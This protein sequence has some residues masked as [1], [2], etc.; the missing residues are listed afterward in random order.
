[1]RNYFHSEFKFSLF[2]HALRRG[3]KRDEAIVNGTERSR[4][5]FYWRGM[6]MRGFV[7]GT[8]PLINT[9]R[10]PENFDFKA[11]WSGVWQNRNSWGSSDYQ[12]VPVPIDRPDDKAVW[13]KQPFCVSG[14]LPQIFMVANHFSPCP[15]MKIFA[16]TKVLFRRSGSPTS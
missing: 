9:P 14:R 16:M 6:F 10:H 8:N 15:K 3:Q 4:C 11:L 7:Q 1:M 13:G 5:K 12:G 2:S